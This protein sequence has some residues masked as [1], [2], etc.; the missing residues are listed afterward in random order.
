LFLPLV[1]SSVIPGSGV[2]GQAVCVRCRLKIADM[3]KF[4]AISVITSGTFGHSSAAAAVVEMV[5]YHMAAVPCAASS[6]C[7]ARPLRA[8]VAA[9]APSRV[10]AT[11]GG[12]LAAAASSVVGLSAFL[13]S[14]HS[15]CESRSFLRGFYPPLLLF[16][17]CEGWLPCDGSA[18]ILP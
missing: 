1:S 7:D 3:R 11:S 6:Q 10:A 17:I 14:R 5:A 8:G 18:C 9:A 4:A 13:A 12:V 2:G 15:L 16:S